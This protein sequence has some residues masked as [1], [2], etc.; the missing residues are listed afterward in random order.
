[1]ARARESAPW[2]QLRTSRGRT[3]CSGFQEA[4]RTQSEWRLFASWSL[5][6]RR[7][8]PPGI[9]N[10]IDSEPFVA[11]NSPCRRPALDR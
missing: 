1:M 10:R 2:P 6:E 3:T 9:V 5:E 4:P 7:Y 11:R 8:G